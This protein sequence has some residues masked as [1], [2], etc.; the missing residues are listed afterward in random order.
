MSLFGL[1]EMFR[2][3]KGRVAVAVNG[4]GTVGI[5]SGLRICSG[6]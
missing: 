5:V 4:A 3:E 1:L 2:R 6:R